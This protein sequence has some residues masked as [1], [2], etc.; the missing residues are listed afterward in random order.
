MRPEGRRAAWV[1]RSGGWS[2]SVGIET[3]AESS[4]VE[5]APLLRL[6]AAHRAARDWRRESASV[7]AVGVDTRGESPRRPARHNHTARSSRSFQLCAPATLPCGRV[8]GG[9]APVCREADA[10][11][12][13]QRLLARSCNALTPTAGRADR[14]AMIRALRSSQK[15]PPIAD[16]LSYGVRQNAEVPCKSL[17]LPPLAASRRAGAAL[18]APVL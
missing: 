4:S 17:L 12:A 5:H 3:R 1:E 11:T 6:V 2:V 10:R 14:V 7:S 8:R 16:S 13:Q 15:W 18:L 9:H